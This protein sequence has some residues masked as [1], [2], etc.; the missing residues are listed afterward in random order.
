MGLVSHQIFYS[1]KRLHGILRKSCYMKGNVPWKLHFIDHWEACISGTKM[2]K[3]NPEENSRTLNG[4]FII[5]SPDTA[6]PHVL[7]P[8]LSTVEYFSFEFP[9]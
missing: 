1:R 3:K 6:S 8:Q 4:I 7:L 5:S 9:V 2:K